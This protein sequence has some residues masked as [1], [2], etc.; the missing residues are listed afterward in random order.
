M[1]R[2][3]LQRLVA[4]KLSANGLAIIVANQNSC[5]QDHA[6]LDGPVQDLYAA[7]DA[8]EALKFATLPIH[9]ASA[10]DIIEVKSNPL[11]TFIQGYKNLTDSF[12]V[13]STT[14]YIPDSVCPIYMYDEWLYVMGE[15]V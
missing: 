1:W 10:Q 4:S 3:L 9:N 13:T 7:R 15:C 5:R 11:Y 8:F 2:E 12:C 14:I 6:P